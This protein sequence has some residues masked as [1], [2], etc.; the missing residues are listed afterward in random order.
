MWGRLLAGAAV[1]LTF[2]L[3]AFL[4]QH[5]IAAYGDARYAAGRAAERVAQLPSILAAN[6]AAAKAALTAR[7]RII[8]ADSVHAAELA[9]LLLPILH[10]NDEVTAYAATD[11]GRAACLDAERVRGIE[12]SRSAFFPAAAP[13]APGIGEP[14]PVPAN[15][16]GQGQSGLAE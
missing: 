12:A 1:M 14:R 8:T 15:T 6:A 13:A 10:S 16:A 11:A 2:A 7:D 4:G 9:R 3:A 5:M